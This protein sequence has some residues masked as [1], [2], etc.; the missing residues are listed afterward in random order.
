VRA[1]L[2]AAVLVGAAACAEEPDKFPVVVTVISDDDK[3]FAAVPVKF[4]P[5]LAG[6]TDADGKLRVRVNGREGQ[7]VTVSIDVPKGYRTQANAKESAFVLRHLVD[8]D[9]GGKRPL[10][11]EHTIRL[12]PLERE[13]AILIRAG[14]PGLSVET[15]GQQ[16]AVTNE[17]GVAMFLYKGTPGDELQVKLS[18]AGRPDL[19]PQNPTASFLL[20]QKPEAYVV[21]EHFTVH[22]AAPPKKRPKPV[23]PKRL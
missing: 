10:P 9:S 15:F 4:G 8:L 3:P 5:N 14:V 2:V 23:G 20:A 13:Y 12:S 6:M 19:R 22:K 1:L 21:K 16:K 11:I 18:T 17:K 7:K